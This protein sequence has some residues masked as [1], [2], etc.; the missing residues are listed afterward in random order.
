MTESTLRFR[1][2]SNDFQSVFQRLHPNGQ[3]VLNRTEWMGKE[4]RS[5]GVTNMVGE[6]G[7]IDIEVSYRPKGSI[8]FTGTT[9][10]DG[11]TALMLDRMQDGTL[12]DGKGKPLPDGERPVYREHEIYCDIDFNEI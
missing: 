9:K 2:K 11:W 7:V 6:E 10:Y 4:P 3:M 1:L 8:T 5:C 12:L